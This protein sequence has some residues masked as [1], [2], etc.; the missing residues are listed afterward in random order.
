MC[1]SAVRLEII[2]GQVVNKRSVD[3]VII[4]K[5][6]VIHVE[7]GIIL[8]HCLQYFV[9]E[10]ESFGISPKRTRDRLT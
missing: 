1:Y 6:K 3:K 5:K 4:L 2:T 9:D 8:D 7:K 10:K